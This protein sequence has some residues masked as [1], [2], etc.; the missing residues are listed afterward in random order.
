MK[1]DH[2]QEFKDSHAPLK[3]TSLDSKNKVFL[4]ESSVTVYNFDSI[5]NKYFN[6]YKES[7]APG[8]SVD[9]ILING[10]KNV[11]IEFK[12]RP[13]EQNEIRIKIGDSLLVFNELTN[14]HLKDRR[15][16]SDFI[17]VYS[18]EKNKKAKPESKSYNGIVDAVSNLA[19]E[20]T[21]L[22]KLEKYKGTFFREFHTYNEKEFELYL[23]SQGLA[24]S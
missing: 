6:C 21:I 4:S 16:D 17:L 9:A 15:K 12:N 7:D 20:E 5:K 23:K 8:K 2:I 22:F 24:T 18:A 10:D 13:I 3:N 1:Y 14:S 11:F 19:K